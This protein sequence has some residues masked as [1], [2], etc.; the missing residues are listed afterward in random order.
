MIKYCINQSQSNAGFKPVTED[1]L[2]FSVADL[3]PGPEIRD[4]V[5]FYPLDPRSGM[6][7][8]P[9]PG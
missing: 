8:F 6:H 7:F 3:D 2:Q 5:I 4:P 9:D 1:I